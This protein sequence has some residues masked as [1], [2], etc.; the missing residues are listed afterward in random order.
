MFY[1]IFPWEIVAKIT[2]IYK[3]T[4]YQSQKHN[5][6]I[7]HF[8][9]LLKAKLHVLQKRSSFWFE[10]VRLL[11]PWNSPGKN[12]GVGSHSLLQGIFP[13]QRQNPGLLHQRQILYHLSHQLRQDQKKKPHFRGTSE[14]KYSL[15]YIYFIRNV[16]KQVLIT[17]FLWLYNMI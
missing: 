12:T 1:K 14:V 5:L 13:T 4:F 17:S 3:N 7:I 11:C 10:A 6:Q 8:N 15:K 9:W 2:S 16:L